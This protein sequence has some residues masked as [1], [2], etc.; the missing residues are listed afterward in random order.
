MIQRE[1]LQQENIT[2]S[3]IDGQEIHKIMKAFINSIS[4]EVK[5]HIT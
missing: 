1:E 2:I 5:R 3:H 4:K